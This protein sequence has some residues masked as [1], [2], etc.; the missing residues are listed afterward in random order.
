MR[1]YSDVLKR[2]F[3]TVEQCE[4][5]EFEHACK[6][7]EENKAAALRQK[8]EAEIREAKEHYLKLVQ[9]YI[10]DYG[11]FERDSIS[12]KPLNFLYNNYFRD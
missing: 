10:K 2:I 6:L 11:E 4:A 7:E 3:E 1:Y 5:A 9:A 8:R 12:A